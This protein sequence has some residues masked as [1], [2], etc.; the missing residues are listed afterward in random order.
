MIK[1]SM[2]RQFIDSITETL[3]QKFLNLKYQKL[4]KT[5]K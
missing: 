3:I 1:N 4:R 2:L 5:K